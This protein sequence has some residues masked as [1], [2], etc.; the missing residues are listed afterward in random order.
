MRRLEIMMTALNKLAKRRR[1]R[2]WIPS[3]AFLLFL[4]PFGTNCGG[5]RQ[6]ELVGKWQ[7]G[8]FEIAIYE[9]G[10]ASF[11]AI[12]ASWKA[13]GGKMFRLEFEADGESQIAE[14]SLTTRGD[15]EVGAASLDFAG[16]A[17]KCHEVVIDGEG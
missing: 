6:T 8:P 11:G 5:D 1:A 2:S 17:V 15:E 9:D 14:L 12:R 10:V 3:F 4:L 7:C 13:L 16:L